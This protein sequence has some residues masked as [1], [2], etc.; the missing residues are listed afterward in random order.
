MNLETEGGISGTLVPMGNQKFK[1]SLEDSS[2]W[3]KIYFILIQIKLLG[4]WNHVHVPRNAEK[5]DWFQVNFESV[6][7]H[8]DNKKI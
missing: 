5:T 6:W 1:I 8:R 7:N 4:R 3:I 2:V